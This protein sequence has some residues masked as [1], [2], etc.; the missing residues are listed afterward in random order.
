M[1]N[2]FTGD[3]ERAAIWEILMRRDFEAYVAADWSRCADDFDEAEFWAMD[4]G[5]NREPER[6]RVGFPR[7]AA[8]RDLWLSMAADFQPVELVGTDKLGFLYRSVRLDP[9][10]IQGER[11]IARKVFDGAA[12]KRG[13][14][15]VSLC[16]QTIYYLRKRDRW[17]ITG[18]L[19][20]L[21]NPL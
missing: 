9:I 21:P 3:A 4:A 7:L 5:Q 8:Y 12:D 16:W 18:F 6:W 10:D 17:R 15:T 1:N 19:G 11:A 2:P 14:G 13:G 20:Y